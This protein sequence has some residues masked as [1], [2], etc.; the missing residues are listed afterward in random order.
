MQVLIEALL[1]QRNFS[2]KNFLLFSALRMLGM[3]RWMTRLIMLAV[4]STSFS[5][6]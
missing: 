6:L 5:H 3:P 2:M 4:L 1:H